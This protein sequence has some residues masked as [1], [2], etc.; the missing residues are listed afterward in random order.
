M[1]RGGGY[2]NLK[3]FVLNLNKKLH[4]LWGFGGETTKVLVFVRRRF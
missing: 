2:E 4:Y 1:S 3:F